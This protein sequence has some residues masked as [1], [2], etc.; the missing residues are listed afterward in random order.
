MVL[1]F[2]Y[3]TAL[4]HGCGRYNK[5]FKHTHSYHNQN[6]PHIQPVKSVGMTENLA[7][8]TQVQPSDTANKNGG[9]NLRTNL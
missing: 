5:H 6:T 8:P 7:M 2:A 3:S 9:F 4:P 1:A